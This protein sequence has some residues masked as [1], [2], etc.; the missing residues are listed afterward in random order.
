MVRLGKFKEAVYIKAKYYPKDRVAIIYGDEKITWKQLNSRINKLANALKLLGVKKGDKVAFLFYNSPQFLEANLAAQELGAIP[1]PVNFRYVASEME[2]LLNNSDSVVFLFDDDALPELQKIRDKIPNVKYLIHDGSNTPIDMLNYEEINRDGKDKEIKVDIDIHDTAVIIYTGGTTGRPKGVMLSYDNILY[3]EESA[4]SFLSAVLPPIEELDDPIYAKNE[5]QRRILEASISTTGIPEVFFEDP[6]M[7]DKVMVVDSR[8]QEGPSLPIMTYAIREGKIKIFVGQP[9]EEKYHGLIKMGIAHQTRDLANFRPLSYSRRGKFILF[10]KLLK[11]LLTG[12]IKVTGEKEVKKALKKAIRNR[13]KEEEIDKTLFVPPLFH[14]A[15]Y[16]VFLI[17]WM[18][19]GSTV[20]F[21]KSKK[22]NPVELLETIE[23]EDLKS[24]FLVPTMWKRT[25]DA[26]DKVERKFNLSSV[27][28]CLSGAAVLRG[29]LKK[30]ILQYFPNAILVDAFGQTEMAPVATIRVDG[31]VEKV[32]DRCVGTL[33]EGLEMK[34]VDD[35]NV[36]VPEGEIGEICYKGA[37]VMKGYYKDK[38]KTRQAID[39]DGFLHSGDLGYMKDGQ[40]YVVERK[41]ECI[42]TG[43]EKVFPLEVEEILIEHPKIDKVCVIGVPDE[44][45]GETVRAVVVLK[46]GETMTEEAVVKFVEGKIAGYKKP[47]S[48]VFVK[49]LP[50]SPVGK[51][52]RSKIREQYG[53]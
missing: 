13:P 51:V 53:H 2:F 30:K 45:W 43:G 38:V 6:E 16:A 36:P 18:F 24:L 49:E 4:L 28:V 25:I 12:R 29:K 23:R 48:V 17:S 21:L 27:T 52:L 22:F 3:N 35:N 32:Q 33:L 8:S 39:E 34:V 15:S 11:L 40:F 10:F 1:V 31:D 46:E 5:S 9:S 14:L 41:K 20:V 37:S 42:N 26:L 44:E 7:H 47:R 50:I 19:R